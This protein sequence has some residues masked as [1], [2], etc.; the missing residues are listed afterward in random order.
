MYGLQDKVVL[1]TGA[2]GGIGA[3]SARGLY[4]HFP[5]L[6]LTDT[7]QEAVDK[8]AHEFH[9]QRV[10]PLPF[11]VTAAQAAKAVIRQTVER[12]GPLDVTFTN[13]GISWRGISTCNGCFT[14]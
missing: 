12:F 5:R 10:L 9:Y 13:A 4:A 7:S 11:D 3:A 1:I 8:Q 6:V 14:S 2:A